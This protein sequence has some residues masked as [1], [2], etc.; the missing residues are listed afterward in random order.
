MFSEERGSAHTVDPYATLTESLE[1]V[2]KVPVSSSLS[3]VD[4][5]VPLAGYVDVPPE[6]TDMPGMAENSCLTAAEQILET[7]PVFTKHVAVR[8]LWICMPLRR[9]LWSS[10]RSTSLFHL[11]HGR[12]AGA[13]RG[14][15]GCDARACG[16]TRHGG[17]CACSRKQPHSAEGRGAGHGRRPSGAPLLAEAGW[18]KA[19]DEHVTTMLSLEVCKASAHMLFQPIF[20]KW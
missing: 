6:L 11:L 12:C 10:D 2:T 5:Q 16:D 18:A 8:T 15:D 19:A 7:A 1:M 13:S 9:N 3:S 14:V 20:R 17:V 4:P